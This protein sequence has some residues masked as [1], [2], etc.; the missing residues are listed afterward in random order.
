MSPHHPFLTAAAGLGITVIANEPLAH[1]TTFH[2]G[3]PADLYAA[4]SQIDQLEALAELA[5]AHETPITILG[6]GSNVLVS[7]AGVRGLVIANQTRN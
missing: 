6:G 5:L 3:G 7:D 2:I 4:V 1:H